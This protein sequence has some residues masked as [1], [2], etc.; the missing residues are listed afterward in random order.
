MNLNFLHNLFRGI[1]AMVKNKLIHFVQ[2]TNN[3]DL[4]SIT[5]NVLNA[6]LNY[7]KIADLTTL[8]SICQMQW[9]GKS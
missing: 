5:K 9:K 8:Q 1:C 6:N 3:D 4:Q 7:M 2:S